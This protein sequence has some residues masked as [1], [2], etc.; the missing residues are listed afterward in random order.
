[1]SEDFV[2]KKFKSKFDNKKGPLGTN[3]TGF[4]SPAGG[5]EENFLSLDEHFIKHP[6][7]T[8]FVISKGSS[9]LEARVNKDDIL[10]IDKS[11][12][13]VNN[14]IILACVAGELVVKRFARKE[15]KTFLFSLSHPGAKALDIT[16]NE[17]FYIEGVVTYIIHEV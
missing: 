5:Y 6:A 1:M 4:G 7:A 15:G 13:P 9:A 17:D 11:L 8:Y 16:G 3:Y 10:V 12:E 14:S 2:I